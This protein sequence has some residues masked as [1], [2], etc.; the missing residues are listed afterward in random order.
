MRS[1]D[2]WFIEFM[3]SDCEHCVKLE[4][5]FKKAAYV[6]KDRV[7]FGYVNLE[8]AQSQALARRFKITGIPTIVIFDYGYKNKR[9]SKMIEYEGK[10]EWKDIIVYA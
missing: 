9:K 4:P 10:R 6:M 5:K 8:D 3:T 1:K 7:K 2:I